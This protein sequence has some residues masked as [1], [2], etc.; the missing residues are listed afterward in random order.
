[1]ED[2]LRRELQF[3]GVIITDDMEMGAVANH[4]TFGDMAAKSIKAGAD[5]VLICHEYEHMKEAYEGIL[6]SVKNG[7][8]SKEELEASVS[9][10]IKMK[11]EKIH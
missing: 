11:L 8:I 4:Y 6:K 7:D 3:K 9:R 2:L 10:I 1:M 5:I